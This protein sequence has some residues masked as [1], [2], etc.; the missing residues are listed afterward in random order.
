[1]KE[2]EYGNINF[3]NLKTHLA[4]TEEDALNLLFIGDT[5]RAI[6][7]TPMNLASSRSHCIFTIFLEAREEGSEIIRRSKLH[8]VDLAGSERVHKTNSGGQILREA[9]YINSSLHFLEMVI[10]ALHERNTKGRQ[11]IPYRN[12]LMTSVLRDSLGGNCITSMIATVSAEK[13]ET[14]ET[15]STCRFAQRVALIK[16]VATVNEELDPSMMIERLKGQISSLKEEN[17]MLKDGRTDNYAVDDEELEEL[18]SLVK[19]WLSKAPQVE[20]AENKPDLHSLLNPGELSYDRIH[21]CFNLLKTQFYRSGSQATSRVSTTNSSHKSLLEQLK[22]REAKIAELQAALKRHG[23]LEDRDVSEE[24]KPE[25][26][27]EDTDTMALFEKMKRK[28]A[29]SQSPALTEVP[30]DVLSDRKSALEYFKRRYPQSRSINDNAKL[31]RE[32]YKEAK[33]TGDRVNQARQE[34]LQL[35]ADIERIRKQNA[36]RDLDEAKEGEEEG[37][38]SG[39]TD[40]QEEDLTKE[41]SKQ[42]HIYNSNYRHLR[43]QKNEIMQVRNLLDRGM[44]K[45]QEDF[46]E[47]F[48][49][50]QTENRTDEEKSSREEIPQSPLKTQ[51]PVGH[52]SQES[53]TQEAYISNNDVEDENDTFTKKHGVKLSGNPEADAEIV[54]FYRA[55]EKLLHKQ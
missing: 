7:E 39:Q 31:L 54:A 36:I 2:D 18:R 16:N 17:A 25:T 4:S 38:Y 27:E 47:W 35:K 12:S 6:A 40:P 51:R 49:K 26:L 13:S 44:V 8:L 22:Q 41:M 9:K 15:I 21:T 23:L 55:R 32:K 50:A 14:E 42:K 3:T 34:M 19:E 43:E 33:Q 10:V 30:E 52:A 1:M 48:A 20:G 28:K 37:K 11:H 29:D 45:L 24:T 46:E 5:N 53:K